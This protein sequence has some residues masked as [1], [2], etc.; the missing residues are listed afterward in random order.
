MH[1]WLKGRGSDLDTLTYG[2]DVVH[3]GG[4][5]QFV[6][7]H[8]TRKKVRIRIDFTPGKEGVPRFTDLIRTCGWEDDEDCINEEIDAIDVN[9][10]IEIK[11]CFAE[12]VVGVDSQGVAEVQKYTAGINEK[13]LVTL[14]DFKCRFYFFHPAIKAFLGVKFSTSDFDAHTKKFVKSVKKNDI[15]RKVMQLQRSSDGLKFSGVTKYEKGSAFYNDCRIPVE[16]DLGLM[17]VP[18]EKRALLREHGLRKKDITDDECRLLNHF[19]SQV[20]SG[21]GGNL[22]TMLDANIFIGPLREVPRHIVCH[23]HPRYDEGLQNCLDPKEYFLD[24]AN[25]AGAWTALS[26]PNF[27]PS[28]QQRRKINGFGKKI[29]KGGAELILTGVIEQSMFWRSDDF[30]DNASDNYL[31]VCR[32]YNLELPEPDEMLGANDPADRSIL[33]E[34]FIENSFFSKA[35]RSLLEKY[36][37]LDCGSISLGELVQAM[38]LHLEK[39]QAQANKYM[40]DR[41]NLKKD[42]EYEWMLRGEVSEKNYDNVKRANIILDGL[43][44]KYNLKLVERYDLNGSTLDLKT[45]RRLLSNSGS[46]ASPKKAQLMTDVVDSIKPHYEV[47]FVEKQSGTELLASDLGSGVSQL[48]PIVIGASYSKALFSI[49]QPEL[50]LHPALQ[51]E[52]ADILLYSRSLSSSDEGYDLKFSPQLI[53]THSEHL[54]LRFMRRIRETTRGLLDTPDQEH[55]KLTPDEMSVLYVSEASD[56]LRVTP[57]KVDEQGEL[58]DEWPGGFF[59]EG[60]NEIVGGL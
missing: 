19:L 14:A 58:V 44:F 46:M 21:I 56:G 20:A 26:S 18:T 8:N 1:D 2:G 24:W 23:A 5:K 17:V 13:P 40:S 36:A 25:G 11:S 39:M 7:K 22:K 27:V 48:M 37:Q 57:I 38:N 3:L 49:Q 59:E 54:I 30:P 41:A 15:H 43:H 34:Q 53:E 6:H 12:I 45:M 9:R 29:S 50:H 31:D 60:F 4:F 32:E 42:Y 47:V 16:W 51:C 10:L 55:L 52:T 35:S 33:L 28:P